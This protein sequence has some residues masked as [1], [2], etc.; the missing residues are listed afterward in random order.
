MKTQLLILAVFLVSFALAYDVI[1]EGDPC[2]TYE[3]CG[4]KK[5]LNEE[6]VP[7]TNCDG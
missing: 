5:L 1:H 2:S 4:E 3:P 7:C 6:A